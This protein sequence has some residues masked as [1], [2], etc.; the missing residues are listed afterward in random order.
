MFTYDKLIGYSETGLNG[1]ISPKAIVDAFQDASA[2]QSKS[3][4][5]GVDDDIER[6]RM[7]VLTSWQIVIDEFPEVYRTY[8]VGTAPYDFKGFMGYRNFAFIDEHGQMPVKA[9]SIWAFV[10]INSNKPVMVDKVEA[11][12]YTII[13]KLEMDYAPRKIK[14]PDTEPVTGQPVHIRPSDLDVHQH[15]NNSKYFEFA[16]D[17]D[18]LNG[19]SVEYYSHLKQMRAEY[20]IQVSIND[21]L[22]P[23]I[24]R[25]TQD[26][27]DLTTVSLK[28]TDDKTCVI[29]EFTV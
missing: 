6:G 10:D 17:S 19:R 8:K 5:V 11:D 27:H 18:I 16:I 12:A 22:T 4:G 15:V 24:Y 3:I 25:Y 20:K 21:I 28:N 7:W 14:L 9:N 13:D 29:I 2:L 23:Y 26:S 1:S